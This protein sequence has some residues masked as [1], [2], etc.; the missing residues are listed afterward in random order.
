MQNANVSSDKV[1]ELL[2]YLAEAV[3]QGSAVVAREAPAV[4]H[5]IIQYHLI[6]AWFGVVASSLGLLIMLA[7]FLYS[8]L[9]ADRDEKPVVFVLSLVLGLVSVAALCVNT[10][11]LVKGY[12]APRLVVLDYIVS[13]R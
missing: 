6:F 7:A 8:I 5:E 13:N 9:G 11:D 10:H 12:Y 3:K 2:G 4:A 1:N